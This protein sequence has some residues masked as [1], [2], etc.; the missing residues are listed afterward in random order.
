MVVEI[1]EFKT[2]PK[3]GASEFIQIVDFLETN[4]HF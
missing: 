1:V 3:M 4:F 2:F